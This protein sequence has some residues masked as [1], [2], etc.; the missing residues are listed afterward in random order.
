M[1]PWGAKRSRIKGHSRIQVGQQV[2][3]TA[4]EIIKVVDRLK[5]PSDRRTRRITLQIPSGVL[6]E[7]TDTAWTSPVDEK[8][9]MFNHRSCYRD[10]GRWVVRFNAT[11]SRIRSKH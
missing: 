1:T 11:G 2:I 4:L 8:A 9:G 7:V 5:V 6:A 10:E 3:E